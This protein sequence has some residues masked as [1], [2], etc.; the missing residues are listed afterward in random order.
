MVLSGEGGR[1]AQ[2]LGAQSVHVSLSHSVENAVA[3]VVL[4]K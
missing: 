2:Q 3:I 4:E 1:I